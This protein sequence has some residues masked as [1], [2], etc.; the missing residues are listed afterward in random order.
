[1]VFGPEGEFLRGIGG[2]QYLE[3]PSSV[4]VTPDGRKVFIVDTGSVGSTSH[5]IAVFDGVS[6]EHLYYIG[7][8]GNRPGE[9]NLPREIDMGPDG[10]LYV[11]DGGNFRVQVLEPDGTVVRT[12]GRPGRQFGQFARPK[13]IAVDAAGQI[14]VAD[15]A[16][17][18]YQIF[19][20]EGELLLFV[21]GRSG[22]DRPAGYQLPSGIAVDEDGR[23]YFVDQFFRKVDIYRPAGLSVTDGYLRQRVRAK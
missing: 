9:F 19:S 2:G 10:R 14:Y 22:I 4:T 23:V 21:G 18:N 3:K 17:G 12:F 11:V 5:R 13:G 7:T 16:F 8:R 1:V 6:G 15:A 20:P